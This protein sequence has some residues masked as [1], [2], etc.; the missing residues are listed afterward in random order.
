[1]NKNGI[2]LVNSKL[3][4]EGASNLNLYNINKLKYK[5]IDKYL[6]TDNFCL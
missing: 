2:N 3:I 1:M 5:T 4:G 6:E